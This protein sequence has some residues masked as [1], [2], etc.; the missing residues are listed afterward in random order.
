MA[1]MLDEQLESMIKQINEEQLA[2]AHVV[3]AP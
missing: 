3:N 1:G 2:A